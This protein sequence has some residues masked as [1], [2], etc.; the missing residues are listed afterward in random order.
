MSG[1]GDRERGHANDVMRALVFRP[2]PLSSHLSPFCYP[3]A[4]REN[5]S[6]RAPAVITRVR[7][8]SA[9]ND[10]QTIIHKDMHASIQHERRLIVQRV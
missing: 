6:T 4:L 8:R 5:T 3:K 10:I 7:Y 1:D 9:A 2:S